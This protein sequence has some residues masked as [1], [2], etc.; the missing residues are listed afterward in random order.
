MIASSEMKSVKLQHLSSEIT[1][2]T[3]PITSI[4]KDIKTFL[5]N[6]F[7]INYYFQIV[8][9]ILPLDDNYP[10]IEID[11]ELTLIKI[12]IAEIVLHG[13]INT[14][15]EYDELLHKLKEIVI[16]NPQLILEKICLIIKNHQEEYDD[17]IFSN[18]FT[19]LYIYD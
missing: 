1:T 14:K 18:C 13:I 9:D 3:L 4:I 8:K 12:N 10:I 17:Y 7:G 5:E 15:N 6:V 2:V 11:K 19:S 16:M